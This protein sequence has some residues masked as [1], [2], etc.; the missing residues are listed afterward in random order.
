MHIIFYIVFNI[1]IK[2]SYTCLTLHP[3]LP[4]VYMCAHSLSLSW[5]SSRRNTYSPR[6][7]PGIL[8]LD[9]DTLHFLFPSLSMNQSH[10]LM[11]YCNTI[12][13]STWLTMYF[14]LSIRVTSIMGGSI[15][16]SLSWSLVFLCSFLLA[17]TCHRY[18]HTDDDT[19]DN[20]NNQ[21]NDDLHLKKVEGW[22]G[23]RYI[24]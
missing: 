11:Q 12:Y 2:I 8:S 16:C 23:S 7:I 15:P 22:N 14:L 17:T 21:G 13:C 5:P 19:Q 6:Y 1:C 10:L 9:T 3:P 20:N 4:Y 24:K 18:G